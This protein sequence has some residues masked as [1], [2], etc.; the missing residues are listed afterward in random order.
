MTGGYLIR[1]NAPQSATD[2][3]WSAFIARRVAHRDR[4][5]THQQPRRHG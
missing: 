3:R 1:C 2:R 5:K 4:V